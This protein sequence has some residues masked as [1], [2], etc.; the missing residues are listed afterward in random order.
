MPANNAPPNHLYRNEGNGKFTDV[1]KESGTDDTRWGL[2]LQAADLDGDDWPDLY[3]ANDFGVNTYYRNNR[4]GTFTNVAGRASV[5]DAG[6]GMGVTVDDYDG[7]GRLDFYV[8][9]Y[10]F[11]LNW[12]LRDGRY[13]MPGF[14]YSLFRPLV[15]RRLKAMSRGSSLFRPT[16]AGPLRAHLRRGGR[17]GHVMVVGLACSSTATSTGG[18][19]SSSSTAW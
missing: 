2:A 18:R 1:S 6:F 17:V 16:S 15:W 13:P 11:P 12:F 10:S 14:P 5:K 4:D 19:T 9:N 8:S 7:D 3:V